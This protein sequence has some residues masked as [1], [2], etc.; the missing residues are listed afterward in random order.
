MNTFKPCKVNKYTTGTHSSFTF[1]SA[2]QP[3]HFR[4][5]AKDLLE[6]DQV[7]PWGLLLLKLV[8]LRSHTLSFSHSHTLT[9]HP[10]AGSG[11]LWLSQSE[12]SLLLSLSLIPPH[13]RWS[14]CQCVVH[15]FT[16]PRSPSFPLPTPSPA[17]CAHFFHSL[18][19]NKASLFL[20]IYVCMCVCMWVCLYENVCVCAL[21]SKNVH[22]LFKH[23]VCFC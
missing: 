1:T 2:L 10:T 21:E 13:V 5:K 4:T 18:W 20:C 22:L 12:R 23:S 15:L 7:A 9:H 8:P 16:F 3:F 14:A 11:L 19:G 17:A 6:S